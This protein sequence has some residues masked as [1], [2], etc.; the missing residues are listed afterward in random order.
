VRVAI[1]GY[2]VIG[3]R[4]ADAVA[5]QTDMELAGVV[6]VR[7]DYKA[8]L[9]VEKGYPLYAADEKS[10][11]AL[12]ALGVSPRGVA[13]DLISD[14][15]IVVDACPDEVGAANKATYQRLG[16]RAIFQGGEEH[17]VAG[18]SFV[19]QCN[20]EA[21]RG[22]QF[23]RVVSCNTTA[24]CRVLHSLD[25][26]FGLRRAGVVIARRAADPDETGKGPI[27]A[28][29]LDP[30]TIPSHH[31]HDVNTVLPQL[32]IVTMA[33]KVP[34]THMH[35]HSLLLSLATPTSEAAVL[36]ALE[37]TPRLLLITGR[38]GFKS[39]ASVIDY[40]REKKRSRNDVYEA[41]VWR[42]SVRADDSEAYLFLGVHQEAIVVPE[43][44]DAIRAL[45]SQVAAAESMR[46]TN[47]TLGIA[48]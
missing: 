22:R 38:E 41:V 26:Q 48:R 13:D 7:A 16:R 34:T 46:L 31:A 21:A 12:K 24:L 30:V 17:D 42:D 1:N 33:I 39:T 40:A 4:L 3:R 29:S 20:Y 6:K 25:G 44:V 5:A 11:T 15:D 8:R 37:H 19:A 27:D 9:A 18:F 14:V 23:V 2:G 45:C 32:K 35:L 47:Q 36:E 43:N 10:R 28:I